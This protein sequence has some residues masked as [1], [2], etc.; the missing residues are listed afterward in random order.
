MQWTQGMKSSVEW[1]VH[2]LVTIL[3]QKLFSLNQQERTHN[4]TDKEVVDSSH[5]AELFVQ[6]ERGRSLIKILSK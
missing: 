2:V 4:K 1:S 5:D 6:W 3:K